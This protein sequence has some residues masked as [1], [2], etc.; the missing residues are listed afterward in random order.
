MSR[1]LSPLCLILSLAMAIVGFGLWA[2]EPPEA[3]VDLHR[4][5]VSGDEAY[6]EVLEARLDRRQWTRNLLLGCLFAGSGL[7][8]VMA[9]ATMRGSETRRP[10]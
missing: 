7:F 4:A 10:S 8:A 6:Q 3:E 2:V 9:F 1:L 5:R